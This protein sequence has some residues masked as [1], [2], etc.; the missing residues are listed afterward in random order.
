MKIMTAST[1]GLNKRRAASGDGLSPTTFKTTVST[2]AVYNLLRD[3]ARRRRTIT[4]KELARDL[5][6]DWGRS[7]GQCRRLYP[8]LQNICRAETARGRPMLGA[9]V[10]R[11]DGTPGRGFFRTARELGRLTDNNEQSFWLGE[12]D[13]VWEQWDKWI[14]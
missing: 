6:L 5:G 12:R 4:Y 13:R 9:V 10:V 8:L 14:T 3:T 1:C 11:R 2:G 7:F